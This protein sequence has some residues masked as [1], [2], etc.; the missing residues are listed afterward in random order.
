MQMVSRRG[1]DANQ[2]LGHKNQGHPGLI[3]GF[4]TSLGLLDIA[5]H[6]S[7]VPKRVRSDRSWLVFRV[8]PTVSASGRCDV[9]VRPYR[10]TSISE[11]QV[12]VLEKHPYG[13]FWRQEFSRT[14]DGFIEVS[15]LHTFKLSPWWPSWWQSFFRLCA[16]SSAGL[17]NANLGSWAIGV[18]SHSAGIQFI[19]VK[20]TMRTLALAYNVTLK[21]SRGSKTRATA[22]DI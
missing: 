1:G 22:D 12:R 8:A 10:R 19:G 9:R 21:A 3:S 16:V 11:P 2:E 14:T 4:E 17:R 7:S 18:V 20:E 5:L 13:L 15:K 6:P